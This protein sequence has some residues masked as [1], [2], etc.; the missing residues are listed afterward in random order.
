VQVEET[1]IPGCYLVR[2]RLIRDVR[3]AFAKTFHSDQFE[4][5]GMR[6]D[7]REEYFTT[8]RRGVVRGMHFQVPPAEHAKLVFCVAGEVVDVVVDLRR[9]SPTEGKHRAFRLAGVDLGLYIPVGCAH[10]FASTSDESTMFYKVTSVH[11]P[12]QDA[13]IAWNSFGLEWPVE[14][15]ILSE[16]DRKHPALADFSSPFLFEPA[17]P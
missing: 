3:G 4:A 12:D 6:T 14:A 2:P 5:R 11:A 16:R 17:K 8:S 7:W 10:G 9:G 1:G 13:G 15:P